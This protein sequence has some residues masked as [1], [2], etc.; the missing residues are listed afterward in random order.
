MIEYAMHFIK[1]KLAQHILALNPIAHIQSKTSETKMKR[2][3]IT[4][5]LY[6]I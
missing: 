2:S 4:L 3:K 6:I 5:V 1:K